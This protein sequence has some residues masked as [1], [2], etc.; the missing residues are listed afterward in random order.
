MEWLDNHLNS[1][2]PYNSL[3][4]RKN[5]LISS[6]LF[7]IVFVSD[8]LLQLYQKFLELKNYGL[9]RDLFNGWDY[10]RSV[11]IYFALSIFEIRMASLNITLTAVVFKS[12]INLVSSIISLSDWEKTRSRKS[13]SKVAW[14][15][16]ILALKHYLAR[17]QL[18]LH[19][20]FWLKTL[21]HLAPIRRGHQQLVHPCI[22]L[23]HPIALY[24]HDTCIH[25]D[26]FFI[27]LQTWIKV[28]VFFCFFYLMNLFTYVLYQVHR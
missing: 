9:V 27:L 5:N 28:S 25:T 7:V 16:T 1:L 14:W 8:H 11:V 13:F 10:F 15:A 4:L 23:Y 21:L 12:V 24:H 18:C 20:L 22:R 17:F 6:L 2:I 3:S 26:I 19:L